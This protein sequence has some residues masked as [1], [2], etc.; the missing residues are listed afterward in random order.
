MGSD[1]KRYSKLRKVSTM[2]DINFTYHSD[3]SGCALRP[4]E[5]ELGQIYDWKTVNQIH[6]THCGI[7]HKNGQ[8]ISL[9]TDFGKINPCYQDSYSDPKQIKYTGSGRRGNQKLDAANQ[10]LLSAKRQKR[11]V[12]L[13]Q[14]IGV[15]RWRFLGQWAVVS[16]KYTFDGATDRMVWRFTL[17]RKK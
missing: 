14:K 2:D 5:L 11:T 6:R 12:P 13:F 17:V 4:E 3:F 7:Y 15:N 10:A 16:A 8:L 1:R 9:L